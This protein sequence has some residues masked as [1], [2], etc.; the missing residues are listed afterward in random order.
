[1]SGA[2]VS[3]AGERFQCCTP[4]WFPWK[5]SVDQ[6]QS[7]DQLRAEE[8]ES[9]L[10]KNEMLT[11]VNQLWS[12]LD[13]MAENSPESYQKFIQRHMKEG[14]EFMA[15]PEPH[16]CLQTKILEPEERVLFINICRWNRVPAPQ[17]ETHPVPLGAGRLE[18]VPEGAVVDI[19]YNP[20]VLKRADQD[21]IELDQLI[22]L[23]M[24]Y[25]EEQYRATLCHTYRVAP[26]KLK[27]NLH[28][29]R[30]RLQ[31][32]RKQPAMNRGSKE[33]AVTESLLEQLKN[34][35]VKGEE[36]EEI[37][38]SIRL[39][40]EDGPKAL[41]S[42]LIKELSSTELQEEDSLSA[43]KHKLSVIKD[44]TGKSQMLEL[45]AELQGVSSV[46]ECDLSVSKDDLM[47]EVPGRYKL[48]LN[49]P[50]AVREETVTAKY[51]KANR[52]LVVTMTVL[53][54]KLADI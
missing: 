26:F 3:A 8:M 29:M 22:R 40:K 38:S 41:R 17:S 49:L 20:E 6:I 39:T 47:F 48:H 37:S 42:G 13:D 52:V 44:E 18:D 12:M 31:G 1:M 30:D 53:E 32:T 16:L 34:I 5:R 27:G 35:A 54:Q 33:N 36:K 21:Q 11:Q 7:T 14:K 46:S 51:N 15:P 24:K 4:V 28:G 19:A 23:G 9:N 43:P 2:L 45:K 50:E 10:T 25:I